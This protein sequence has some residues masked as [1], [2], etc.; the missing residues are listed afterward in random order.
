MEAQKQVTYLYKNVRVF[1]ILRKL[2]KQGR[3]GARSYELSTD[4]GCPAAAI[5]G[6]LKSLAELGEVQYINGK[7]Y[8]IPE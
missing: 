8:Y 6:K 1:P 7:W 4:L 5:D 2:K 3:K